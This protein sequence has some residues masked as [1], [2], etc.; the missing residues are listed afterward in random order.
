MRKTT[1]LS[2]FF[3]KKKLRSDQEI[4]SSNLSFVSGLGLKALYML[5]VLSGY[6]FIRSQDLAVLEDY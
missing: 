2:G 6:A 1:E 3:K 4:P 5:N